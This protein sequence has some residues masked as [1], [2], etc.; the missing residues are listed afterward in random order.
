MLR[1]PSLLH[2]EVVKFSIWILTT[3]SIPL[4]LNKK[5][6]R[7]NMIT[8]IQTWWWLKR[9]ISITSFSSLRKTRPK[10]SRY[11]ALLIMSWLS[12]LMKVSLWLAQKRH[13]L[14]NL[15]ASDSMFRRILHLTRVTVRPYGRSKENHYVDL[16]KSNPLILVEGVTPSLCWLASLENLETTKSTATVYH[17][18]SKSRKL[19]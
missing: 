16:E 10:Q 14:G 15:R 9:Y 8:I 3:F 5:E 6:R 11:T 1:L 13:H 19:K 18:W 4:K 12:H 17:W 2:Q 7:C